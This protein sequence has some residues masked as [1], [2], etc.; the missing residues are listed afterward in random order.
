M[1]RRMFTPDF[2][3]DEELVERMDI[4]GRMFYLGTWSAAED[5]G[6][7]LLSPLS[8]KMKLF[9]GDDIS[10]DEIQAYIDTLI[11]MKKVVP[12]EIGGKKYGWL[13]NFHRHQK[14]DNP[15]KPTLPLPVWMAWNDSESRRNRNFS[16]DENALKQYLS[17]L[18]PQSVHD[19]SG[20][21]P[22]ERKGTEKKG[23]EAT[24]TNAQEDGQNENELLLSPKELEHICQEIESRMTVHIGR[25]Y[26]AKSN[27]LK[28]IKELI[29]KRITE[30]FLLAGI[31]K[32]FERNPDKRINSFSYCAEVIGEEWE[33]QLELNRPIDPNEFRTEIHVSTTR[34]G[35]Q[36][37]G[38][39]IQRGLAKEVIAAMEED[40]RER[41][42]V[43]DAQA[44]GS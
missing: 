30:E 13:R 22:D 31:D 14:L 33:R 37:I 2:F 6:V 40:E 3:T 25:Q 18:R 1:K 23:T 17:T 4:T 44:D 20:T 39:Y 35:P 7:F 12:F 5:S 29:A 9:P 21:C 32:T 43:I 34:A 24:E 11:E 42:R 16:V 41:Q 38:R 10:G 27:D 28:R 8:L 15:P 36:Q 26:I 19:V